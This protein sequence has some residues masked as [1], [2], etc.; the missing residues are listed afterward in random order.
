[1]EYQELGEQISQLRRQKKISQQI[2]AD[3]IGISR[4]TL[5]GLEA[6]RGGDVG[7]RKV[8]KVLNYLGFELAIKQ[9][10]AFPTFEE[11]RGD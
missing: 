1:M 3:H 4:A 5:N 8:I 10:S 6:G 2:L 7:L 11:L 9:Q